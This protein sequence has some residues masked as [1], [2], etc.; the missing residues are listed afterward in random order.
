MS[1]K[2]NLIYFFTYFFENLKIIKNFKIKKMKDTN[3]Q[4]IIGIVI[5]IIITGIICLIRFVI[6]ARYNVI[7]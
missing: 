7:N 6:A 5:G 2:R 3:N 1:L 4:I